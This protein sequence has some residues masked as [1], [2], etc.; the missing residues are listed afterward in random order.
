MVDNLKCAVLRHLVG[1]APILNPRYVDFAQHYGYTTKACARGKGNEKGRVE[2]G[3]GYVK[4][5]LLNG[6]VFADFSAVNPAARVW[7]DTLA[8]R[9]IHG[10]T[11][12]VPWELFEKERSCLQPLLAGA[13]QRRW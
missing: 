13:V 11:H 4:K 2:S 6:L 1:E 10:E 3:V 7:L 8:N 5:N 12:Q 9:R